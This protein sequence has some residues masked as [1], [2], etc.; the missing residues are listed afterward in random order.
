MGVKE[1]TGIIDKI[2]C[3]D[4]LDFMQEMPPKSIP[5]I[6][7]DPPYNIG[8]AAWD[9]IDNYLDWCGEWLKA[10]ERVLS[11]NGSMYVF[12]N[13]KEFIAD[14]MIWI[15]ENTGFVFKNEIVWKKI[16][17]QFRNYGFVQQ[18]L[19][20]GTMRNYYDGFTEYILFYTFQDETGLSQVYDDRDCFRG[21]KEYL[22]A[23]RKKA[24]ITYP[25]VNQILGT[26]EGSGQPGHYFS[27][28]QWCLPTAEMYGKLQT[29]GFFQRP[30]EELRLEYEE[31]RYTF[32]LTRVL[33]DVYGNSNTWEYEP[34]SKPDHPT[35]KPVDL[36]ENIIKHSSNEGDVILDPFSGSGTTAVAAIRTGRHW[37]GIDNDK[38]Y[39]EIARQRI[40]DELAQPYML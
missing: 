36:I 29:T 23:E 10:C 3:R 8:K 21:I 15:R 7:A 38:G 14:L 28:S 22:R 27:D 5:L 25:E 16:S 9:K 40:K 11:D 12:H 1:L 31:L 17:P 6:I 33:S 30:Y 37:I 20:N 26:A 32:N 4:S 13:D 39:C 35:Q 2:H 18:R 34:V 19:S 24:G